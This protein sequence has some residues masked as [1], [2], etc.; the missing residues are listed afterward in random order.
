MSNGESQGLI[1]VTGQQDDENR[2]KIAEAAGKLPVRF[3]ATMQDA[4]DLLGEA[5]AVAGTVSADH[6]AA[7][8]GLRWVHSWAAGANNDLTPEMVTSDVVLTSSVGN[9]AI[10]LAEHSILLMIML[11]RDVPRW[12]SNQSART[13]E[14][15][16]HGELN[17]KTLGIYGVGHA[18]SDLA[19]K[20]QAF[21]MRVLGCRR[22]HEAA[23]PG[24][25]Q[26]YSPERLTEFVAECD[27][28]VVT[29]PFTSSTAG[30]FSADVFRSMKPTAFWI[31]ISRG[32]IADD[33]AL[34]L[35]LR[36]GWIAGAGI[37]AHGVEPLPSDSPFWTAPNTIITPHNG[38]TTR[39]TAQRG[40]EIFVENLRRFVAG[41]SL[42]NIVD[43]VHGY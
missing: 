43:K 32:G 4:G 31:C 35:A 15:F 36:E 20:A 37:D 9:G 39:A 24:I 12:M 22:N 3:V 23:V 28:V 21:H 6:L 38:A 2:R 1:V 17:G 27:F 41:Q 26:M 42:H 7:A 25:D 11:N 33:D 10:P 19:L 29:A 34:L 40:V 16:T 5:V 8:P 13:W 30:A 14:R 18:G